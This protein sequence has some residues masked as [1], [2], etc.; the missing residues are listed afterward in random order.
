MGNGIVHFKAG[1][2]WNKLNEFEKAPYARGA[3]EEKRKYEIRMR[4]YTAG[5]NICVHSIVVIL[6]NHRY[7]LCTLNVCYYA[8][9]GYHVACSCQLARY[10]TVA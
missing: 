5:V 10:R 7:V 3:E 4:E 8:V 9:H 6:H 1:E 2:V